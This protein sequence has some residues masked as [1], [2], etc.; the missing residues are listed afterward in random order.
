MSLSQVR[1]YFKSRIAEIDSDFKEHKD[2]FN[3]ENI[4]KTVYNKAYHISYG[5]VDSVELLDEITDDRMNVSV[6]LFFKGFRDTQTALDTS[7]DKANLIRLNA[8]KRVNYYGN[9]NIKNIIMTT[10]TPEALESNDN[11]III[12]LNFTVRMAFCP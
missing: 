10:L 4:G 2:A 9:T 8:V 12:T 7:M 3:Y 11:Q 6:K 1:T 5:G